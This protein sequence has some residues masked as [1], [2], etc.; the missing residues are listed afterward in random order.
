MN[1][2]LNSILK[3]KQPPIPPPREL[4]KVEKFDKF[5]EETV[6]ETRNQIKQDEERKLQRKK[7][8]QGSYEQYLRSVIE[9]PLSYEIFKV[10]YD[11]LGLKPS[12]MKPPPPPPP[13][14][15]FSLNPPF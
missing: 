8:E 7:E 10:D 13:K 12:Y 14:Q 11:R 3:P 1:S 15:T 4:S 6:K 2:I 5:F 9:A